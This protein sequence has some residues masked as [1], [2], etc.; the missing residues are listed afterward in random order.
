MA[1]SPKDIQPQVLER[2]AKFKARVGTLEQRIDTTL[3]QKAP[4]PGE[5]VQYGLPMGESEQVVYQLIADYRSAGWE[6]TRFEGHPRD[7]CND[8]C[9]RYSG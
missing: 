2:E 5:T 3:R 9:F 7:A 4:R 1:V 6:V 8:L